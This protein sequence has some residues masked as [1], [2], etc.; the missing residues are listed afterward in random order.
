MFY[1]SAAFVFYCQFIDFYYICILIN[2]IIANEKLN[3]EKFRD[4]FK[5]KKSFEISDIIDFYLKIEPQI[6]NTTINWRIY[7][8]MQKGVLNRIGRGKYTVKE[9]RIYIPEISSKIK[10]IHSKLSKEFP[11]LKTCIWNTSSFNEFM[12]HQPGRFYII[13]EVEKDATQSVF[14]YLKENKYS[15]FI[16]PSKDL[17]EKYIP[18]EK[19]TLIVKSLVSEAPV[20]II[21]GINTTTIEK[22]LVDIFCDEIIFAAQQGSEMRNIFQEVLNKYIVNENRMLR[23]ADRRR[24]KDAFRKYVSSISNSRQ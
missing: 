9:G 14:Y 15:V 21:N 22:M 24:K 6:K 20:Q 16:E 10:S 13:I 8:L 7:T 3:I 4:F 2:T 5:A 19:E 18:D 1:I 23:Y 11:Y 17:I 12:V